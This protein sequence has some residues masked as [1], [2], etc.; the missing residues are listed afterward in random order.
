MQKITKSSSKLKNT[1]SSVIDR[2]CEI[3]IDFPLFGAFPSSCSSRQ[4]LR[5]LY[6]L[7]AGKHELEEL[8]KFSN[9]S[10]R[11]GKGSTSSLMAGT[12]EVVGSFMNL[13]SRSAQASFKRFRLLERFQ[14]IAVSSIYSQQ[15]KTADVEVGSRHGAQ[16]IDFHP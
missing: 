5:N 15:M 13:R 8:V 2:G 7:L 1:P 9:E 12:G 3:F 11:D 14:T 6:L 10:E 16:C 4:E